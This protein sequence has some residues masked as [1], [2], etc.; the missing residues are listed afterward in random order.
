MDQLTWFDYDSD[1]IAALNN[2][3]GT[4]TLVY[5]R[6]KAGLAVG[7]YN[8]ISNDILLFDGYDLSAEVPLSGTVT[9]IQPTIPTGTIS[10]ITPSCANTAISFSGTAPNGITYYWQNSSTGISTANNAN[11]SLD[12]AA[13]GTYFVRAKNNTDECWSDDTAGYVVI[14]NTP[15]VI[16]TQPVSQVVITGSTATFSAPA[17]GAPTPTY[18]WEM[19]TGSGWVNATGTNNT[20]SYNTGVTN[21]TMD[22]YQYRCIITNS[23]NSITSNIVSLLVN[24]TPTTIWTNPINNSAPN[25][26]NPY[27]LD[28]TVNTNMTV[29]GIGRGTGISGNAASGRY[30]A[31]GWNSP[32]IDAN[33]YFYFIL[34]PN[35]GFEV[36]LA[37]LTYSGQASGSGPTSFALKS[38]LDGFVSNIGSASTSGTISL[39]NIA[40][41]NI[42]TSIELRL[43]GWAA[44]ATGGTYS[45]NDFTFSGSVNCIAPLANAIN[46]ANT[47][48]ES[49]SV[50]LEWPSVL[51]ADGYVVVVRTTN[52]DFSTVA[53]SNPSSLPGN[54]LAP[55]ADN[56]IVYVGATNSA[57]IENLT[58]GNSYHFKVYA[59]NNCT[60]VYKFNNADGINNPAT[61]TTNP[62]YTIDITSNTFG[63]F[64]N[65]NP[66]ATSVSF[67]PNGIF[68][69]DFKVQLS[70]AS[71]VFPSNTTDNIIGIGS[72]SPINA[73]IPALQTAGSNYRLRIVNDNP[74]TYG[75]SNSSPII[76]NSI[77]TISVQP[78]DQLTTPSSLAG[79]TV[80]NVA[81]ET[82]VWEEQLAGGS[83][84]SVIN[85]GGLYSN[86]NTS[87]LSIINPS[88]GMSGNKYRCVI[89]NDCG[90]ITSNEAILTVT[91]QPISIWANTITGS[92]P[93]GSATPYTQGQTKDLNITVS[94]IGKSGVLPSG[95]PSDNRY[96]T[97]GWENASVD[98]N[99]YIYF[100]LD[101][102]DGYEINFAALN[103]N[104]QRSGTGPSSFVIRSSQNNYATNIGTGIYNASTTEHTIDL[105]GTSFQSVENPITFRIY[106][107]GA[108]GAT[109]TFS[110]NDFNFT[111]NIGIICNTPTSLNVIPSVAT[112]YLDWEA[113]GYVPLN[114]YNWEVRT[115]PQGVL[116]ASGNT[117]LTAANASGLIANT[118]YRLSVYSRC[119]GEFLSDVAQYNFTTHSGIAPGND[120]QAANNQ[121]LS[122]PNYVYPNCLQITG[123]TINSTPSAIFENLA[124]GEEYNDLWYQ[125]NAI[126][127]GTSITVQSGSIDAVIYLL[128]TNLNILKTEN[129]TGLG[130]TER[131]NY[132]SLIAGNRYYIAIAN[133][134][135]VESDGVFSLCLQNLRPARC[136]Q[137]P[138]NGYSLC[139]TFM[140]SATGA[141]N[142]VF[143]FNSEN[144]LP[145]SLTSSQPIILSNPNL[146]LR[147]DSTYTV[148][149]IA[150]YMLLDGAGQS[151]LIQISNQNACAISISSQPSVEV[152]NNQ[153]CT[154]GAVL[155]RSS[156]IQG[157][158]ASGNICGVT[159]YHIE[160]TPVSNCDG[161]NPQNLDA[162]TK[163]ITSPS[164]YISLSYAFNQLTPTHSY[165][166]IGYW[167]VRWKPLFGNV[168]G[169]Y[170]TPRIIAVNGTSQSS[171]SGMTPEPSEEMNELVDTDG[172][173]TTVYPNPNNGGMINLN[174][175]GTNSSNVYVRILDSMGKP[176]YSEN[177]QTNG[178]LNT[179]VTF[180]QPLAAGLYMI[181]FTTENKIVTQKMMVVK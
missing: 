106:A 165:P 70:D 126:S 73:S 15:V 160:F 82:F 167:S 3:N 129:A 117:L 85:N 17:T 90:N 64:C 95:T 33:D 119:G 62:G 58:A 44:S 181:E 107:Y 168:E 159:G 99:K 8:S 134:G 146:N 53:F 84:W 23:C 1:P 140:S 43:Y 21:L 125:F 170:G 175:T 103:M 136:T 116:K 49:T 56:N 121:S 6:L 174:V 154:S 42:T 63:P 149:L 143:T 32:T 47:T 10:G 48:S 179:V 93:G 152:K 96:N 79:F 148:E 130:E 54:D 133:I 19:N 114:G 31:S 69:S 77:P 111:G 124:T 39:N 162:F 40:L 166:Y 24:T 30:N 127:N 75:V 28:Q 115:V 22:G 74:S 66:I 177:C 180:N 36:D 131:L 128:D 97:Q 98:L 5:V 88:L 101:A 158:T 60:S 171:S 105:S 16:T 35:T 52:N 12:V 37:S 57:L 51:D 14:V 178:S 144:D 18:T 147:Y 4:E 55:W 150:N 163:L 87:A 26:F 27:V 109:G 94:G 137:T 67:I 38:S 156:Y 123:S 110:I 92:H 132:G 50:A 41:Q 135:T 83:T 72:S 176:V 104:V 76:I 169:Q 13:S 89:S 81:G 108:G 9:C 68:T 161:D 153:R 100:T 46:V 172:I 61:F 86:A 29:S 122:S 78:I 142:T 120:N 71:G 141:T 164:A 138:S 65:T 11:A 59:Y 7:T 34:T 173:S 112:A 20:A 25:S 151:Q 45:V 139:S 2:Y 157:S 91:I 118:N 145:V 102:N 155:Y 113:P 80:S